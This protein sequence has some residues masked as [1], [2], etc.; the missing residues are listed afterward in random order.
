MPNNNKR[1]I[2]ANEVLTMCNVYLKKIY[3]FILLFC[4]FVM[5]KLIASN[6]CAEKKKKIIIKVLYKEKI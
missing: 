6:N 4:Y 3:L 5:T 1:T 2:I